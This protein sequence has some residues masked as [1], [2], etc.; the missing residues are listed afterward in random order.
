MPIPLGT[1]KG[2]IVPSITL[3][4]IG[5]KLDFAVIN[6]EVVPAYIFGTKTQDTSKVSGKPK[7]QDKVTVLVIKGTALIA[8]TDADGKIVNDAQG[9]KVLRQVREGDIGVIFFEGQSRY[10]PDV[11]KA[12]AKGEAKSWS[13]AKEDV[14]GLNVGDV[15][16]WSYESDVQ[17]QGAQPRKVR[18]VMLRRAK[19]EEQS[20]TT[21]CEAL[22]RERTSIKVGAGGGASYGDEEPF[23]SIGDGRDI[24][25]RTQV[26]P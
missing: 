1:D 15:G 23:V 24:G 18:K 19:P 5:D 17:G 8:D 25:Y 21:Q 16:R 4:T 14:G 22:Y 20:R 3:P 7:T 2:P 10:D 6:E 9:N 11:D 13:A 12:R 26:A